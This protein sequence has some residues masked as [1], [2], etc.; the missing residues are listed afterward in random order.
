MRVPVAVV[1]LALVALAACRELVQPPVE[2]ACPPFT[3]LT[4][5]VSTGTTPTF[6]WTPACRPD[7]FAVWEED[8]NFQSMWVI[9]DSI[10]SGLR[11][12]VVPPGTRE[13]TAAKPLV[14]GVRYRVS[15][16]NMSVFGGGATGGDGV[17]PVAICPR[18]RRT[19]SSGLRGER[20]HA[21]L[22]PLAHRISIRTTCGRPRLSVS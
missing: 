14:P 19:L 2:S 1:L 15:A 18:A 8:G 17:R 3:T 9:M 5:S 4:L 13:V 12:G 16:S 7:R 22:A 21:K 10:P 11:Y 20:L 6:A